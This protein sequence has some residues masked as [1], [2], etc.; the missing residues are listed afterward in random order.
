MSPNKFKD[1]LAENNIP[2]TN[3]LQTLIR[4]THAGDSKVTYHEYASEIFKNY[5]DS[6]DAVHFSRRES[7]GPYDLMR[8]ARSPDIRPQKRFDHTP[9]DNLGTSGR[10]VGQDVYQ[11]IKTDG[12]EQKPEDQIQAHGMYKEPKKVG[13]YNEDYP[14]HV[15]MS[16]TI[17]HQY[18]PKKGTQNTVHK[19]QQNQ[20]TIAYTIN[21][22]KAA[23]SNA[24]EEYIQSFRHTKDIRDTFNSE[25]NIITW[26]KQF[27]PKVNISLASTR[28]HMGQHNNIGQGQASARD[29]KFSGAYTPNQGLNRKLFENMRANQ[30]QGSP[31]KYRP[32]EQTR[33]AGLH[34]SYA[35]K[36][37]EANQVWNK[38]ALDTGVQKRRN[39]DA[40]AMN[41]SW[42]RTS[43][44]K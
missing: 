14:R 5:K 43:I 17:A 15:M 3:H 22:D 26:K 2:M 39:S 12:L 40:N 6:S 1:K 24:H 25:Q 30:D 36:Q 19:V 20:S 41:S 4:R 10:V 16:G 32:I 33:I 38:R 21:Q 27:V 23:Q 35:G 44:A 28:S 9:K 34:V 13:M 37:N 11:G 42:L 31:I 7:L 8:R 29:Q 18:V